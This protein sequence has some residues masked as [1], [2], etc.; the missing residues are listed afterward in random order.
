MQKGA[1]LITILRSKK[2]VFS[3]K[4]IALLWQESNSSTTRIRLNYY[5]K[6][7]ALY[8]IRKGFYAKDKNY[9]K[10]ELATRIFTPAYVSF[11][12]V[13][14]A[15]GLIFQY[16]K[17]FFIASYLSREIDID[18]QK[19]IYRKIKDTALTNP[20]GIEHRHETSIA[21]KERAFLDILYINKDYYFDNLHSLDWEKV[22]LILPIYENDRMTKKVN[23]F[24][25][26]TKN[27]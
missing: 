8:Q 25:K 21:T 13:L 15:E 16:Y 24:Y 4:D 2:T 9:N 14:L 7:K 22:F 6:K 19:Y 18:A 27:N 3:S 11:E 17:D 1:Y 12:T 5:V 10:L 20:L 26:Q 23:Q